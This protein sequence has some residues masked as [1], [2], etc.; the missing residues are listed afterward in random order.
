MAARPLWKPLELSDVVD[1][2]APGFA[3]TAAELEGARRF[4]QSW[5][6]QARIPK[7]LYGRDVLCA[8]TDEIRFRVLRDALLARD[9]KAVWCIRGG[10]GANRLI[11]ELSR[12]R[13]PIGAPKLFIGLSDV[14]TLHVFLN[15]NWHWPTVHGPLLDRLGNRAALPRYEREMKRFVFGELAEMRFSGLR[16]MNDLARRKGLVIDGEVSG[17]NLIVLQSTIGTRAQWQTAGRILFFEEIGE[18]GYRI[19]RVLEHFD[20]L[21]YF[22]RARA[23]I[24]GQFTGGK[25][26]DGRSLIPHVLKRFA[27]NASIPVLQGLQSGHDMIQRPV[28]FGAPSRL[29]FDGRRAELVC[30]S[31]GMR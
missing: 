9:S 27:A 26:R 21:G 5:G 24:F 12:L 2:I 13:K 14:T 1:V 30:R 11:P 6:L 18:R 22:K 4:L 25:E 10:Y 15:Q 19:D 3:S 17:G 16:P 7:D 23:I 20:Q 28:P 31:G 8:N 29:V